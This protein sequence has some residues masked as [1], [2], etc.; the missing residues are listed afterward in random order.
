[1]LSICGPLHVFTMF[2][3][4]STDI[5]FQNQNDSSTNKRSSYGPKAEP[6]RKPIVY[7]LLRRMNVLSALLNVIGAIFFAR[8]I[9]FE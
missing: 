3:T 2:Q 4:S 8:K 1:M 6:N 9:S 5:N 7:L